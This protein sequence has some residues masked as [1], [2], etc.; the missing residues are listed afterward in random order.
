MHHYGS[1]HGHHHAPR[2]G[3]PPPPRPGGYMPMPMPGVPPVGGSPSRSPQLIHSN[4]QRAAIPQ[5]PAPQY[6]PPGPPNPSYQPLPPIGSSGGNS[7]AAPPGRPPPPSINAEALA[8]SRK[9]TC[10]ANLT[11]L[12]QEYPVE[13]LQALMDNEDK[14]NELVREA[15]QTKMHTKIRDELVD[16]NKELAVSSISLRPELEV[17]I[18]QLERSSNEQNELKQLLV[19]NQARL[20]SM[21]SVD[22]SHILLQAAVSEKDQESDKISSDFMDQ[23]ITIE[24]FLQTF[25]PERTAYHIRKTKCDKMPNLVNG[26]SGNRGNPVM[27]QG[28]PSS[29]PPMPYGQPPSVGRGYPHQSARMPLPQNYFPPGGYAGY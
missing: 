6:R 15:E 5:E 29:Q 10:I 9:E 20:G 13:N 28:L 17:A 3:M 16:G 19:A 11:S 14:I 27:Q 25:I 2:H 12:V 22:N 1:Q 21:S 8:T 23:I 18:E 7:S 26:S 24:D 4:Y